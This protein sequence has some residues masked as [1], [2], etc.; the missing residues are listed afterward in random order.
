MG[1][2]LMDTSCVRHMETR[3][4]ESLCMDIE[5]WLLV[6]TRLNFVSVF[7]EISF[8]LQWRI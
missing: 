6:N 4:D 2:S 7:F 3:N 1:E 8:F 5:N